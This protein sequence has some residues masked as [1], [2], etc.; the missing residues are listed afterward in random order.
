MSNKTFACVERAGK[1]H[2]L[3]ER[4]DQVSAKG[5]GRIKTHWL[6]Q[7]F[8]RSR[9]PSNTDC[10]EG[11]SSGDDFQRNDVK[12]TAAQE[13]R[14]DQLI[15]WNT[16]ILLGLLKQ[17]I[18]RRNT[19]T[20]AGLHST[21]LVD[22]VDLHKGKDG[23]VMDCLEEVKEII[24][25]PEFNRAVVNVQEDPEKVIS[26]EE[27]KDQMR[28]FVSC[29]ASIHRQN[30]FHNFEH[31]SHVPMSVTKLMS[32]VIAPADFEELDQEDVLHDHT[33][34]VTSH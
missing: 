27:L 30:A 34:G 7:N 33:C 18:A 16:E 15:S 20:K 31:A 26:F 9:N 32:C 11:S 22:G 8:K 21:P 29:I 4:P 19:T 13:E 2:W 23:K 10:S 5:L 25:L 1:A 6:K 24:A 3:E 14:T 12:L 28:R 17:V